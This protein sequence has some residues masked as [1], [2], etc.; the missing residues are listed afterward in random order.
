L[1][2]LLDVQRGVALEHLADMSSIG[3][4][5]LANASNACVIFPGNATAAAQG[6][7]LAR[8]GSPSTSAWVI[9]GSALASTVYNHICL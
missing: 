4:P 7:N 5:T 9:T 3:I 2:A 1:K 8:V 6:T